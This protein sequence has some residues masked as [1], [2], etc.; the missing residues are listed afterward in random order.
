[1][2]FSLFYVNIMFISLWSSSKFIKTLNFSTQKHAVSA[3]DL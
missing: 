1:M 2:K 3:L